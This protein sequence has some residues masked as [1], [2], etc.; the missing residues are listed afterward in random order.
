MINNRSCLHDNQHGPNQP[1]MSQRWH[2]MGWHRDAC[3]IVMS[4]HEMQITG[5]NRSLSINIIHDG[6]TDGRWFLPRWLLFRVG[7]IQVAVLLLPSLCLLA[8]RRTPTEPPR[9]KWHTVMYCSE[10]ASIC[11]SVDRAW[12]TGMGELR[13]RITPR[14]HHYTGSCDRYVRG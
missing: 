1:I 10:I 11:S 9:L 14:W 2:I 5:E 3:R 4:N 12:T 6:R 7:F 8:C 13:G